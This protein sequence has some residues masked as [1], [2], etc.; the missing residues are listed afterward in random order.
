MGQVLDRSPRLAGSLGGGSWGAAVD[1]LL[2]TKIEA[3]FIHPLGKYEFD[4]FHRGGPLNDLYGGNL[5]ALAV[6]VVGDITFKDLELVRMIRNLFAHAMKPLDFNHPAVVQ[7]INEF[8]V[9]RWYRSGKGPRMRI[10]F[11]IDDGTPK[12]SYINVSFLHSRIV[13]S[14]DPKGLVKPTPP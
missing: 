6:G 7:A 2:Q 3:R 9:L 8:G 13:L 12:S 10:G 1:V 14:D 11:H 5:I 4:I